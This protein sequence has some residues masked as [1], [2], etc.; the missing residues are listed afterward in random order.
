MIFLPDLTI[1]YLFLVF[2]F[3][4]LACETRDSALLGWS[5]G[6]HRPHAVGDEERLV[7]SVFAQEGVQLAV[8]EGDLI[9]REGRSYATHRSQAA[10][11]RTHR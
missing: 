2:L 1:N 11:A 9:R 8:E 5:R 7:G 3:V 4:F 6:D 10:S